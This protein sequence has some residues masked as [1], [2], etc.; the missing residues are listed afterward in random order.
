MLTN[1]PFVA[2]ALRP[3]KQGDMSWC[4]QHSTSFRV[5]A[6]RGTRS[7]KCPEQPGP[8]ADG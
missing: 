8:M 3:S 6:G 5:S 4:E 7:G 1:V 2:G